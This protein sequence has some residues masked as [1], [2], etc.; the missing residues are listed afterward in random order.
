MEGQRWDAVEA[1]GAIET[2][3]ELSLARDAEMPRGGQHP[4]L[5]LVASR[6]R[7]LH[8]VRI[9]LLD[10]PKSTDDSTA[11]AHKA[12]EGAGTPGGTSRHGIPHRE[13]GLECERRGVR[14][15]N[16]L[17]HRRWIRTP[18]RRLHGERADAVERRRCARKGAPSGDRRSAGSHCKDRREQR[19][20]RDE[21]ELNT[22]VV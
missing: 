4:H 22:A 1:T 6:R 18:R 8:Q 5:V 21:H 3:L 13:L 11:P 10:L 17:V 12:L 20:E 14:Q 19:H 9:C 15:D 16:G 7:V 2:E